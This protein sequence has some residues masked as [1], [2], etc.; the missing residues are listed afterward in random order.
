MQQKQLI[1]LLELSPCLV[2]WIILCE[3]M[4]AIP[5]MKSSGL[6]IAVE[7]ILQVAS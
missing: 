2:V 7:R 5:Y 4:D 3:E 1:C 6:F